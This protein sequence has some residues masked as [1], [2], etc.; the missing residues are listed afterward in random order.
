MPKKGR[1]KRPQP[2]AASRSETPAISVQQGPQKKRPR[3]PGQ[4]FDVIGC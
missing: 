4:F 3:R 1:V 2:R